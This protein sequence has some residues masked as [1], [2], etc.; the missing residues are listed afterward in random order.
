MGTVPSCFFRSCA[1]RE[2][3]RVVVQI[4]RVD[5]CAELCSENDQAIAE[6]VAFFLNET[7]F[8]LGSATYAFSS[9]GL[10]V[11]TC[12]DALQRHCVDILHSFDR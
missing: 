2:L 3:C 5:K 7:S 10:K 12:T 6:K 1:R 11:E 4:P 8:L 9:S